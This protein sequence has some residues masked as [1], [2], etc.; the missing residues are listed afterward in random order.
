MPRHGGVTWRKE[1]RKHGKHRMKKRLPAQRR[2][3]RV[4]GGRKPD[5]TTQRPNTAPRAR[6]H[7][8]KPADAQGLRPAVYAA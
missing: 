7:D 5:G 2:K 3:D 1:R 8:S 4:N 6:V